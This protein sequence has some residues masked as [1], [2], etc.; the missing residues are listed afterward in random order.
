MNNDKLYKELEVIY[1]SLSLLQHKVKTMMQSL[2]PPDESKRKRRN[3]KKE[4]MARLE[5]DFIAGTWRK[6]EELKKQKKM[7]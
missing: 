3:L 5:E 2:T 7:P 6:P 4:R 1:N